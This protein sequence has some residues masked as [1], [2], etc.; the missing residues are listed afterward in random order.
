MADER[1]PPPPDEGTTDL[2][3]RLMK[4]GISAIPVAGGPVV[5][6][7]N[8]LGSPVDRRRLEWLTTLGEDLSRLKEQVVDLTDQKLSENAAFVSATLQ[9]TQI[10]GR[11]H[12]EEKLRALRGAVLNTAAGLALEDDVQAMFLDAV[13]SLTASHVRFLSVLGKARV[14]PE[15]QSLVDTVVERSRKEGRL[16]AVNGTLSFTREWMQVNTSGGELLMF[17]DPFSE[18]PAVLHPMW[19]PVL[20]DILGW[21]LLQMLK[22][23]AGRGFIEVYPPADQFTQVTSTRA[24]A[25]VT[26]QGREFLAF[27]TSPLEEG[28][29]SEP[30]GVRTPPDTPPPSC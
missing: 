11:T 7:M 8:V 29:G 5:E 12:R 14:A 23:L 2:A 25:G 26:G 18:P 24:F 4:A 6:L 16:A 22:D 9:A 20:T 13:D 30:R 17:V 27:I 19:P 1:L 28:G 10:A 21:Q 3:L 15:A